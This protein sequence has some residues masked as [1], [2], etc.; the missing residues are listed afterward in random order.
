MQDKRKLIIGV[1]AL[2]L[3]VLIGG[4]FAFTGGNDADT[5]DTAPDAPG[6][7]SEEM[8]GTMTMSSTSGKAGATVTISV[9]DIPL[10]AAAAIAFSGGSLSEPIT[11]A[12]DRTGSTQKLFEWDPRR[13]TVTVHVETREG[14]KYTLTPGFYTVIADDGTFQKTDSTTGL[15]G[16]VEELVGEPGTSLT[17]TATVAGET[18]SAVFTFAKAAEPEEK[19]AVSISPD[20]GKSGTPATIT[21]VGA[22]NQPVTIRINGDK[23]NSEL[24]NNGMTDEDGKFV[25]THLTTRSRSS[26]MRASRVARTPSS[27]LSASRPIPRSTTSSWLLKS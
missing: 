7:G 24:I 20:E 26:V 25:Q 15:S 12:G 19:I 17:I 11:M 22:P 2:L 10:H 13:I 6:D 5:A 27:A 4:I 9:K 21:V 16:R 18:G 1:I 23:I 3:A 8:T 14:G